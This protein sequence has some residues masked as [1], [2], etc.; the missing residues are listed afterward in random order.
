MNLNSKWI[1][2]SLG[3]RTTS[4]GSHEVLGPSLS[5]FRNSEAHI[6]GWRAS[7]RKATFHGSVTAFLVLSI[8]SFAAINSTEAQTGWKLVWS[9]EFNGPAG[10]PPDAAS[11]KFEAGP[12]RY[13]GGNNEA[14][15]YCSF[16]S[17]EAPCKQSAPNAYLDGKGHLVIK[18]IKTDQ[19]LAIAGK[20]FS[21]PVYTSARIDSLKSFRYGRIE[22]N[23]QVPTGQG[24]WPAFWGLGVHDQSLNWPQI[25]EMDIMEVWNPQPGTTRIDPFLNHASVHG[26][27]EPGSHNGYVDVTGTYSFPEP[28]QLAFHQFA[29]E[30]SPGELDFYCDGNLYSRQ[31]VGD[32]SDKKVWEMD[33]APF[34]LLLNLAMGGEFFGYPDATTEPTPT[35]VVDYVRVYQRDEKILPGGWGNADIG[36][37]A[38]VGYASS[39]NGAWT[40][41]GSGAGIAGHADQFQFAYSPLGGDGEVSAHVLSQASKAAQASSGVMIRNGRGTGSLYATVLITP[42]GSVHFR[43]RADENGVPS[44]TAYRGSGNWV[45]VARSGDI[46]TGYV[47]T[48][49][50]SWTPVGHAKLEMRRDVLG[51]LLST[52]G[53]GP[54]LNIA[55]FDS[56]NVTRS[57]AAWDGAAVE[58]PGVV[59]AEE[60]DAGGAGFSYPETWKHQGVSAFRPEEG[61]AIKQITTHGEP[62]VVPGGYYLYDLPTGAYVNYSVRISKAANYP[63]RVRVSSQGTGGV[64]HFN[65]DGKPVTKQMHIPDTGGSENWTVLYIE[66]VPLPA[67]EHTLSLVTDSG[68]QEGKVGNVDYFSVLPY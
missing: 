54:S 11:W 26:P 10:S 48:D 36:G 51:G 6:Q 42:N 52:S 53:A 44:D 37:P 63:F 21:S 40:L 2:S 22:A 18:A 47:S 65:L 58:I 1:V 17:G 49:G 68:G 4:Q 41:A 31:S 20:N 15:T 59:Q 5:V 50:K 39:S 19:T 57:E 7:T 23:I 25:G 67:G 32:L 56:V 66:P 14:E 12:G 13:V 24:V 62:N 60:F 61:P 33:N 27:N 38:E 29:V 8:L 28:M 64:I 46:F 3:R 16:D 35:M 9:D 34:Y 30:W 43:A 55:Q 45:K